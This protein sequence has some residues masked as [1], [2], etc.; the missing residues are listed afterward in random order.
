MGLENAYVRR[1]R[2]P[3]LRFG[4]SQV[5]GAVVGQMP[6]Y[7]LEA[8]LFGGMLLLIIS[9]LAVEQSDLMTI[10]PVLGLYGFAG[11]RLM[12][13]VQQIFQAVTKMRFNKAALDR[14]YD[15]IRML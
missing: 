1:F 14:L 13:V 15:D 6:R 9:L 10:L 5:K 4:Q 3:A 7:F 12:P 11:Y 8:V 2:K